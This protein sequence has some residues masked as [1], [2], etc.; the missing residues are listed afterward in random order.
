MYRLEHRRLPGMNIPA[1]RHAEAALQS[2]GEVGDDVA[3]HIIGH[4]HIE[5]ARIADHLQAQRVYAH[6]HALA[7][8]TVELGVALTIFEGIADDALDTL[9]RVDVLLNRDFIR[10]SL[11][12]D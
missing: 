1:G 11:L 2:G 12:E 3:E 4:D 7:G 6:E 9:A 8:R 5:P 10:R